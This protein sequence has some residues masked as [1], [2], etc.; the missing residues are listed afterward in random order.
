MN[1]APAKLYKYMPPERAS[2]V[3]GKLLIRFSQASIMNDIEEF[4]PPFS[5]VATREQVEEAMKRRAD[6]LYPGLRALIEAQ[7]PEYVSK[8][9]DD[10]ERNLPRAIKTIYEM[11]DKNFGILSLS[12]DSTSAL[13][14]ELYADEGRGFLVDFD[15]SHSWFQQKITEGDDLRHL[16]RVTY[17]ADRAPAYLLATTAQDYLYTKE[18]KWG[19]E[20][21]WRIILNFNS[22]ASKIGKD[23]KGTDILLF[24]IPPECILSV[25]V[26]Y[27]ASPE[28]VEQVRTAIAANPALS[29]VRLGAARRQED[30][31]IEI[32]AIELGASAARATQAKV[33]CSS[34]ASI[35]Y[36][37]IVSLAAWAGLA[38]IGMFWHPLHASS[39][40]TCLLAMAV[41]CFAN[42]FKNR[43]YHCVLTGPL[44]L[45]AAILLLASD[46]THVKPTLIWMGVIAGTAVAFLLE[47]RYSRKLSAVCD[48]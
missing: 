41:G 4:K 33:C 3:L 19:Y 44:F 7:G 20:K 10:A 45:I 12:E 23:D 18:M 26:G 15:P 42:A 30:G 48:S 40:A 11:N 34:P 27:S 31:S 32:G 8:M 25:T 1:S 29:H 46:L 21:E 22:A 24:A 13:M 2:S 9:V 14:W 39:A 6:A 38:V 36:W 47:W 37:L 35:C 43:T 16:R 5:G 17:V 28:F